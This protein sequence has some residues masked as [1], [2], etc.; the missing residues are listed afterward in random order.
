[1]ELEER[2]GDVRSLISRLARMGDEYLE[3]I[4]DFIGTPRTLECA[5]TGEAARLCGWTGHSADMEH[6]PG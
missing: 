1:M 4:F 5:E 3:E 2:R 6:V